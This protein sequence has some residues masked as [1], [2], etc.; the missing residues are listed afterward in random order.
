[1]R[2]TILLRMKQ[3]LKLKMHT[4]GMKSKKKILGVN[5]FSGLKSHIN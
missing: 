1:M 4:I 2:F 3:R 5:L